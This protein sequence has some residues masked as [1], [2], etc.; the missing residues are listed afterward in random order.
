MYIY[1]RRSSSSQDA[2]VGASLDH[3]GR[4]RLMYFGMSDDLPRGRQPRSPSNGAP[5]PRRHGPLS[6][7]EA[8]E[9]VERSQIREIARDCANANVLQTLE[10]EAR[11]PA[12]RVVRLERKVAAMPRIV[13]GHG[14][15]RELIA[16]R[17]AGRLSDTQLRAALMGVLHAFPE[18]REFPF[19]RGYA[20]G[21]VADEVAKARC[22]LSR[23]RWELLVWNRTGRVPG[24]LF[25]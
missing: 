15:V 23:A 8:M 2:I 3:P 18:V 6:Y 20:V 7:R 14:L 12:E 16:R 21:S 9:E 10:R 1:D 19:P 22:E 4:D 24:R 11:T 25:R 5:T 13:Q 17:R